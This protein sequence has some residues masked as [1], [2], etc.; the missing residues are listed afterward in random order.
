MARP[1][2]LTMRP[3]PSLYSLEELNG[4]LKFVRAHGL[5]SAHYFG[6]ADRALICLLRDTPGFTISITDMDD[7]WRTSCGLWWE[8]DLGPCPRR[9]KWLEGI[10]CYEEGLAAAQLYIADL[11]ENLPQYVADLLDHPHGETYTH[12]LLLG[13]AARERP[14]GFDWQPSGTLLLGT[15]RR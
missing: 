13:E 8:E 15:R 12:A 4:V 1:Q 6:H 11:A 9:P 14:A 3:L 5:R 10:G 2:R 7:R